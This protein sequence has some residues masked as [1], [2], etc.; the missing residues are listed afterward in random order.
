M[1]VKTRIFRKTTYASKGPEVTLRNI[2]GREGI[3]VWCNSWE[4]EKNCKCETST[5]FYQRVAI[6]QTR[7]YKDKKYTY[8]RI[9]QGQQSEL[10]GR[11]ENS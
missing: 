2:W 10:E 6:G 3:D 4:A 5:Q 1:K 7:N 8:K 9:T 11:E